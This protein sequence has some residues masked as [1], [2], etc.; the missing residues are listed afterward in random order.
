M[1]NSPVC[2]PIMSPFI[3]KY[4]GLEEERYEI[5]DF[6]ILNESAKIMQQ[7]IVRNDI[8]ATHDV[9]IDAIVDVFP[10]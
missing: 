2:S 8:K 3:I 10:T 7:E 4:V 1:W 6:V 9:C 5:Q